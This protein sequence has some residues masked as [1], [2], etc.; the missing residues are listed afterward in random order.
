MN[1]SPFTLAGILSVSA[2]L[3]GVAFWV[4]VTVDTDSALSR[5]DT[6]VDSKIDGRAIGHGEQYIALRVKE[7]ATSED[8]IEIKHTL[9]VA[10]MDH[11]DP[12]RAI[13]LFYDVLDSQYLSTLSLD[14]RIYLRNTLARLELDQGNVA[15]AAQF[16]SC[17]LYTS[18]S[19][20]DREK[21]RMPSSA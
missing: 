10:Q 11:G 3:Y 12:V 17:L 7:G 9:A 15:A 14:D 16:F 4:M 19:P 21:S 1:K 8:V 5:F 6:L 2:L 18:P 20:R 13:E